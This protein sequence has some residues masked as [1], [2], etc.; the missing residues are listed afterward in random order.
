MKR[1][2]KLFLGSRSTFATQPE[3]GISHSNTEVAAPEA[4]DYQLIPPFLQ[5]GC[6]KEEGSGTREPGRVVSWG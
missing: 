1:L 5:G 3:G 6:R 2:C 4:R